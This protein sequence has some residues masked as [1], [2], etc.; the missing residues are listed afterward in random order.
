MRTVSLA[1]AVILLML[2]GPTGHAEAQVG[3]GLGLSILDA[4]LR[5][6]LSSVSSYYGVPQREVVFIK[7]ERIRDEEIPVVLF[8][9]N[10]AH[11]APATIIDLRQD[12]RTWM[13]I[14]SRFGQRAEIFYVPVREVKGPPY[15]KAYGYYKK[16]PKHRW[17][18]VVLSDA[19]VVNLVNLKF[20]SDH[21][22]YSPET[23]IRLRAQ[24]KSF[25]VINDE[26]S[27]KG[28]KHKHKNDDD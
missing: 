13:E 2:G 9:A 6:Y 19:D 3:L 16:K 8:M 4:G 14:A 28:W 5:S 20:L 27:R 12:G 26:A 7:E 25:V 15:G 18:K 22:G 11:V 21:H 17:K 1:L 23:V 10:R 24:G